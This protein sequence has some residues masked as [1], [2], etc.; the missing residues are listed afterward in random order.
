VI[1]EKHNY[2]EEQAALIQLRNLLLKDDR[3]RI[4][5]IETVIED[6]ISLEKK[7]K[8]IIEEQIDQLKRNF[9]D[10]YK[11]VVSEIVTEQL[12]DSQEELINAIYPVMGTMIRKFITL[13]FQELKE[14]IDTQIKSTFSS[15]GILGNIKAK[16]FGIEASDEIL[17]AIDEIKIEEVFI[18]QRHSGL[19]IGA[20]S[21]NPTIDQDVIAGMLTAIKAFVEDAFLSGQQELDLIEY[22]RHKLMIHNFPSYFVVVAMNG[23]I[24]GSEKGKITDS[25]FEFAA[26]ILDN[27]VIK[28]D[29]D[30]FKFISNQL[31]LYF[32]DQ[33]KPK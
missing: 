1:T 29:E 2:Q 26:N 27:K 6:P 5:E 23:S 18:V 30:D 21:K 11:K 9:P 32:F 14:R 31:D 28:W 19:L 17:Y 33:Q 13:Q 3:E 22:D 25:I 16:L 12:K 24:S 8:P 10:T 20:A 4:D 15:K 7:V